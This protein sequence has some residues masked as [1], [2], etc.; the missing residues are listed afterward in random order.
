MGRTTKQGIDYFS[1]DVQFDNKT[2]LYLLETEAEGLGVL[3]ILWQMIY[4]NEGYYIHDSKDLYLLIKKKINVDI[5]KINAYINIA[6]ERELF[7]KRLHKKYHI[8]TSKAVQKRYFDAAKRKKIVYVNRDYLLISIDV[9]KNTITVDINAEDVNSLDTKEKEKEKEKVNVKEKKDPVAKKT[10]TADFISE[11][12]EIFSET[13]EK[14]KGIGYIANGKDRRAVGLLLR[15]YRDK[16]KG[17]KTAECLT[18]F[19][20]FFEACFTIPD[21]WIIE[22]ISLPIIN[23][24]INDIRSYLKNGT[25]SQVNSINWEEREKEI[26]KIINA[27]EGDKRT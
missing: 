12:I 25:Y 11:I 1:L 3:V 4:F 20:M 21:S 13:Y 14:H 27:V 18:D 6:L 16:N 8:L 9:Y 22:H 15:S 23:S 7:D 17:K 2:E 26:E 24:K 10:A 5:N 19:K